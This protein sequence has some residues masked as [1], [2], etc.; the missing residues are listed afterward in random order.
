[1]GMLMVVDR[2]IHHDYRAAGDLSRHPPQPTRPGQQHLLALDA[3]GLPARHA[4][5]VV[6]LGRLGDMY[7]RVRMYNLGF[8]IFT[9]FSILLSVTG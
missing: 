8:A 9:V 4:V 2:R 5:L 1:M 7:G 3:D 6:T